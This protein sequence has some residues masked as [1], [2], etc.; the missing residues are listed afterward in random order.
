[1]GLCS[2]LLLLYQ[3]KE[4]DLSSNQTRRFFSNRPG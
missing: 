4:S 3:D 1:M 2:F